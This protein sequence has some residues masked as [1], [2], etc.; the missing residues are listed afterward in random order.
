MS[1]IEYIYKKE[2]NKDI[3]LS[4]QDVYQNKIY[5]R[6]EEDDRIS[7]VEAFE[8]ME[9]SSCLSDESCPYQQIWDVPPLQDRHLHVIFNFKIS[10]VFSD[11]LSIFYQITVQFFCS[12]YRLSFTSVRKT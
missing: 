9:E 12:I 6:E 2:T 11:F 10:L 5:S 4:V 8:W 3:H 7:L 1:V